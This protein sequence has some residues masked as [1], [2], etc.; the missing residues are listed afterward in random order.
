MKNNR[1]I[2]GLTLILIV[3][4]ISS[5]LFYQTVSVEQISAAKLDALAKQKQ[6][7][8]IQE[9][10]G[11]GTYLLE[12]YVLEND[13]I[14]GS[15]KPSEESDHPGDRN[16]FLRSNKLAKSYLHLQTTSP[17]EAGFIEIPIGD[18]IS[19]KSHKDD[20][21]LSLIATGGVI[22]A[23]VV[24][25]VGVFLAIACSCPH[26]AT[27]N[28][29]GTSDFQ[30]SLFPGSIFKSL[31]R[32]DF[33]VLNNVNPNSDDLITV[34]VF[35]DLDEV[36]YIDQ[37]EL[38]AV[39]HTQSHVGLIHNSELMAYN[40]G[41]LPNEAIT[42]ID[43][44]VLEEIIER[45]NS[46]YEFNDPAIEGSLN[47]LELSFNTSDIEKDAILVVRGQQTEL[48]EHTAEVF[49]QQFGRKFPGWVEKMNN[50][51][52]GNY[53]QN[54]IEQGISLNAYIMKNDKWDYLGNYENVGA[55][56][57]RDLA[58]PLDLEGVE[59]KIR[60]KLEA[61]YGFWSID[62]ITLTSDYTS[63]LNIKRLDLV[64]AVNQDNI[65]VMK[66]LENTDN[67][68]LV[69][70]LKGTSTN[71]KFRAQGSSD[72]TYILSGSGYYNHERSYTNAPNYKFLKKMKRKKHSTHN[73][74]QM[75]QLYEDMHLASSN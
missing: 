38:L 52:P 75:I 44:N 55:M 61:A 21:A 34:Q 41:E 48:L 5:C 2:Y 18:I 35:N 69:Q 65:D 40:I 59:S 8:T 51:E 11:K 4:S 53:N 29:N 13:I 45:D 9:K 62:Q 26:V 15:L 67:D 50:K 31:K 33:L 14:S 64:S 25:S 7:I 22:A 10:A 68:Y 30:G 58:I 47:S 71:L 28:S 20:V 74:A 46:S 63:D 70:A 73:L 3:F 27:I 24:V 19:I 72:L 43:R 23:A 32:K 36:Q 42:Q 66:S 60:I 16:T 12:D 39:S 1:W 54:A 49:F 17:L 56:A 37:V 6:Y 57:Q